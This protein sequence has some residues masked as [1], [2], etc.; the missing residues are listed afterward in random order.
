MEE[1]DKHQLELLALRAKSLYDETLKLI[2]DMSTSRIG[3]ANTTEKA[4]VA[5][6]RLS[7]VSDM[8]NTRLAE[9]GVFLEPAKGGTRENQN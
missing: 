7:Q 5:A 4:T 8:L 2:A 1:K 3:L 6:N 9:N